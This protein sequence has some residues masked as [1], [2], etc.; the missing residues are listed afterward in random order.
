MHPLK[1]GSSLK[2]LAAIVFLLVYV[3]NM[4]LKP[5]D[6]AVWSCVCFIP[7]AQYSWR[8]EEVRKTAI[9]CRGILLQVTNMH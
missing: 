3:R 4:L 5:L 9:K 7:T 6:R 1:K 8:H 2:D